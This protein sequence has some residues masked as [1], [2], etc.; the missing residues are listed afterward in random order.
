MSR[1]YR[2]AIPGFETF[3]TMLEMPV[4]QGLLRAFIGLFGPR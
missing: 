3:K 4:D 2:K 1:T